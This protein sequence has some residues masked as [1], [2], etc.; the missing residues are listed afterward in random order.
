MY[1]EFEQN[2]EQEKVPVAISFFFWIFQI[3]SFDFF[4]FISMQKLAHIKQCR[5]KSKSMWFEKKKRYLLTDFLPFSA[6]GEFET[7]QSY[8]LSI[9]PNKD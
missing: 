2:R 3:Q 9:M 1:V 6:G 4:T 5:S 8:W 7:L